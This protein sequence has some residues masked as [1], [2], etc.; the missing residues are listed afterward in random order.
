MDI[1]FFALCKEGET[2]EAAELLDQGTVSV[3]MEDEP[4]V[5]YHSGI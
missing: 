1:K 2:I 3:H 4:Y 5:R